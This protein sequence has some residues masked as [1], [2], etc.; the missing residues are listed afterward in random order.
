M[1]MESTIVTSKNL[2]Q[3]IFLEYL[4]KAGE[5]MGINDL[6]KDRCIYDDVSGAYLKIQLLSGDLICFEQDELEAFK[7][8]LGAEPVSYIEL[9]YNHTE[10][11]V[12]LVM[13]FTRAIN[14]FLPVVLDTGFDDVFSPEQIPTLGD[15]AF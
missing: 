4:K 8:L 6:E 7:K 11:S 9:S 2:T 3:E 10:N 1:S 14:S 13:Q 12:P 5:K 15:L